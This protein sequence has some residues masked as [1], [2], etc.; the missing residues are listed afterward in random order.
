MDSILERSGVDSHRP[1]TPVLDVRSLA[2][3]YE[4]RRGDVPAVRDVTFDI[5]RGLAHSLVGE[6]G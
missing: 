4:T 1:Q 6:S 3:S 2:V 5:Q